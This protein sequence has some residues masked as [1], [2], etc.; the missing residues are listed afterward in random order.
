[1]NK[2]LLIATALA[3]F[4][5]GNLASAQTHSQGNM[6]PGQKSGQDTQKSQDIIDGNKDQAPAQTTRPTGQ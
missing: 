6:Q 5:A 3:A 4:L 1:M 2:K